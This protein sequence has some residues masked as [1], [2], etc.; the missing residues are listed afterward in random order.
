MAGRAGTRIAWRL[1]GDVL[2][3]LPVAITTTDVA[4]MVTGVVAVS[5]MT[6][7]DRC[8]PVGCMTGIAIIRGDKMAVRSLWR[9]ACR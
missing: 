6:V 3:V 2:V 1:I 8:P 5:R 4:V 9:I 7:I